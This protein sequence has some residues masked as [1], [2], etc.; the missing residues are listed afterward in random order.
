MKN[1]NLLVFITQLG[2]SVAVPLGGLL[3]LALWLRSRF[4]WG[5]WV[6]VVGLVL[7]IMI[8]ADGLRSTIRAMTRLSEDKK[9]EPPAVSFNDHD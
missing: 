6:V 7:G 2:L 1:I 4:S 3:L 9:Q 8:A 5:S